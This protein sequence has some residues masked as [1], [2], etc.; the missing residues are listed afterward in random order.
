[1]FTNFL[2]KIQ[3]MH[4]LTIKQ[5]KL[6]SS[7]WKSSLSDFFSKCY[8]RLFIKQNFLWP[9]FIVLLWQSLAFFFF[10]LRGVDIERNMF[11]GYYL[12]KFSYPLCSEFGSLVKWKSTWTILWRALGGCWK[13]HLRTTPQHFRFQLPFKETLI[14]EL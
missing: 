10:W 14:R 7:I 3:A 9:F 8:K 6:R 13:S 2:K 11:I 12:R 5:I 1:M 4:H